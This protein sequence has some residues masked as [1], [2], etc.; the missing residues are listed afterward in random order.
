M[1][2][3]PKV[4]GQQRVYTPGEKEF[5]VADK[6]RKAGIPVHLKVVDTL[7]EIGGE[8]GVDCSLLDVAAT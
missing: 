5:E 6:R 4:R 7:R 3:A 1:R 8:V 2:E